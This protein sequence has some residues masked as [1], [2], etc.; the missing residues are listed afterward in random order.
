MKTQL[1]LQQTWLFGRYVAPRWILSG[2]RVETI[3]EC[4]NA[5]WLA[6]NQHLY[7]HTVRNRSNSS[8]MGSSIILLR[9]LS[10]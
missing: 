9:A 2:S 5:H 6:S 4:A 3:K 1:E 7:G 8:A 10:S